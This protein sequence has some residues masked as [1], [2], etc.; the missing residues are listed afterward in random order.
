MNIIIILW[1]LLSLRKEN[2]KIPFQIVLENKFSQF[3]TY[4]SGQVSK[5]LKPE[6]FFHILFSSNAKFFYLNYLFEKKNWFSFFSLS[7]KILFF[8]RQAAGIGLAIS[9]HRGCSGR[10]RKCGRAGSQEEGPCTKRA[11]CD[12]THKRRQTTANAHQQ[13]HRRACSYA[14]C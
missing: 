2:K 7:L 12:V 9:A 6:F 1:D 3:L 4:I 10:S 11:C 14:R 5:I 8:N 13:L